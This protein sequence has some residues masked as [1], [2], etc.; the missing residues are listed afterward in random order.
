[1][2]PFSLTATILSGVVYDIIKSSATLTLDNFKSKIKGW[3]LDDSTAENL[4]NEVNKIDDLKYCNEQ[5]V[6]KKLEE[7]QNVMDL[8]SKVKVEQSATQVTQNHFGT[9]DNVARDKN[10]TY[11]TDK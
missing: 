6:L 5:G 10:V 1:M 11:R 4:V 9:G 3:I 8:L 7:N 2:E